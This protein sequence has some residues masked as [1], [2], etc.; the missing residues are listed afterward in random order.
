MKPEFI[1]QKL[2]L[3]LKNRNETGGYKIEIKP[4]FI[5]QKI[6]LRV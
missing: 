1:K 6:T 5:E 2:N 4:E 3:R